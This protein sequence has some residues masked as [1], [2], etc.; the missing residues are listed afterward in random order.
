[1][2]RIELEEIKQHLR[3]DHNLDDELLELYSTAALEAAENHIGK[4]FGSDNSSDTVKFTQGIKVG[5]LMFIGHL[6][7]NRES[8]SDVQLYG[9]PMAVKSLWN[10]YRE[11]AIY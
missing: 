5:C 9:V 2:A 6:Y 1:M 11:P 3:I 4:T 7:A 10:P 8:V